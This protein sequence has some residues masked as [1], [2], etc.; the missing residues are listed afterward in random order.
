MSVEKS[1]NLHI[2]KETYML[3]ALGATGIGFLLIQFGSSDYK[4]GEDLL[5]LPQVLAH[6]GAVE[7]AKDIVSRGLTE[8]GMGITALC[9]AVASGVKA[10]KTK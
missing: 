3:G 2:D 10:V 4:F 7:L 1:P 5:K 8:V 6:P 9:G